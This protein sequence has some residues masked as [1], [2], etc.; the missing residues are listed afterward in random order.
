MI[1]TDTSPHG[2]SV[3]LWLVRH[4]QASFG[5]EDYDRLSRLGM[6]Q[7]RVPG[8]HCARTG[9]RFDAVYSG[10]MKRQRDTA[11]LVLER[12]SVQPPPAPHPE[13]VQR[14]R[15]QVDYP[16]PSPRPSG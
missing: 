6:E 11:G 12:Q 4:G 5:E 14:I 13:R 1:E 15:L 8:T 10:E 9:L 7:S 3:K 2:R 16:R